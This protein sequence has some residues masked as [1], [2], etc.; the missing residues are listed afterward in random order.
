MMK[1]AVQFEQEMLWEELRPNL[2][3][4]DGLRK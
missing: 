3:N 4:E 1:T 2:R